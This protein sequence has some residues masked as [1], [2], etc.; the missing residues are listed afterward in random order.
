MS[1]PTAPTPI[2]GEVWL[3]DLDPG[4]G[5]EQAGRRPVLI[6]SADPFNSGLSGLTVVAP[7]TSRLRNIPLHVPVKPPEGGLRPVSSILCDAVRSIDRRH[8][9]DRW[10]AVSP[11]TMAAVEDRVRR[12]MGL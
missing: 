3:A 11:A 5:H 2:R 1:T 9:I 7:L 4:F 10:G 12:L 8:L 6:I